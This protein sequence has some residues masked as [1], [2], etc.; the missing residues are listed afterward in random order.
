M[1]SQNRG[2]RGPM[3]K[4]H[5]ENITENGGIMTRKITILAILSLFFVPFIASAQYQMGEKELTLSGSGTSDND[6]D[7]TTFSTDIG[8]GYFFNPML[9]M[10]IR[11]NAAFAD[12]SSGNDWNGSTRVGVDYNIDLQNWQPFIGATIGYLYGENVKESFI[13]GP[14]GGVKAFVNNTTFIIASVG[15]DFIFEDADEADNA[16]DDGRFIYNLG[17]GFKW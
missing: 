2:R 11:Q 7:N 17:I 1:K 5:S 8:F 14:E 12:T 3:G 13:A 4:N 10:I 6:L 9:E 16:F 15:Y